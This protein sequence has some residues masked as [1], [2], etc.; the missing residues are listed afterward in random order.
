MWRS[1]KWAVTVQFNPVRP[2]ALDWTL[3]KHHAI[4]SESTPLKSSPRPVPIPKS[5]YELFPPA[6]IEESASYLDKYFA[7]GMCTHALSP[8]VPTGPR[9]GTRFGQSAHF[10]K[11]LRKN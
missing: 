6:N 11:R 4:K 7:L 9:K 2:F 3:I 1:L 5:I 8:R 10:D